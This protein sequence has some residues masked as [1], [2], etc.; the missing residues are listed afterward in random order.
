MALTKILRFGSVL[1]AE[2]KILEAKPAAKNAL[3]ERT[4]SLPESQIFL[5]RRHLSRKS[6]R[7]ARFK[8][9]Q[10][11]KNFAKNACKSS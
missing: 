5:G 6:V 4:H 1:Y 2:L 8:S 10:K 7:I 11:R 9:V 3:S